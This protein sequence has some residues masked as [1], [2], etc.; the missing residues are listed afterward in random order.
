MVNDLIFSS[1]FGKLYRIK[2][3]R[4]AKELMEKVDNGI[5][6]LRHSDR[7]EMI[8]THKK[9]RLSGYYSYEI[10]SGHRILYKVERTEGAV[11]VYLHR[12]CDHKNVY[13]RD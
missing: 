4:S 6:A 11:H 12:V 8:G 2:R 13:G 1:Q 7:P 3:K 5:A 10:S 9:G